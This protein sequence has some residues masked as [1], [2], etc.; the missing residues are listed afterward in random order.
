MQTPVPALIA[1]ALGLTVFR[2]TQH[3][4]NDPTWSGRTIAA[5]AELPDLLPQAAPGS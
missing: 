4:S 2:T 1:A 5:L 3:T